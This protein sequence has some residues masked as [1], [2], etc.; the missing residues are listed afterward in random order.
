MHET[1]Q[2][3][4]KNKRNN[5]NSGSGTAT[6]TDTNI[7]GDI[8]S[9]ES[10]KQHR[11]ELLKN[12]DQ[13]V[14]DLIE[15]KYDGVITR[16]GIEKNYARAKEYYRILIMGPWIASTALSGLLIKADLIPFCAL[17]PTATLVFQAGYYAILLKPSIMRDEVYRAINTAKSVYKPKCSEKLDTFD[18]FVKYKHDLKTGEARIN[19]LIK[20]IELIHK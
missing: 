10:L 4:R 14:L 2:K 15:M 17:L 16:K 3:R 20:T 1:T 8:I 13:H 5:P 7:S 11:S 19:D 6:N 18:D 9:L 12:K